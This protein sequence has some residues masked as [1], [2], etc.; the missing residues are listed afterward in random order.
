SKGL[1]ILVSPVRFLVAPLLEKAK[2]SK[3]L[4]FSE[5]REFFI[6]TRY[7]KNSKF[8]PTSGQSE[9]PVGMLNLPC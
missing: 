5:Y 2:R 9:N 3:L 4:I 1:K 6:F 8:Q 7:A